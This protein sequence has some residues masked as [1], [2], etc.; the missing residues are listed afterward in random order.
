MKY[1]KQPRD[2]VVAVSCTA[3]EKR[4]IY[5]LAEL[6]GRTVSGYIRWLVQQDKARG[7]AR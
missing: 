1:K 2:E 7:G 3:Q 6:S 4:E 5:R